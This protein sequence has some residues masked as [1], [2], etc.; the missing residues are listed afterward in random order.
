MFLDTQYRMVPSLSRWPNTQFY[1]GKIRDG[2]SVT[3]DSYV[4]G[5]PWPAGS[6]S[7]FIHC[8]GMERESATGSFRIFEQA[9]VVTQLVKRFLGA[10]SVDVGQVG[11]LS[12]YETQRKDLV[13][14]GL[15]KKIKIANVDGF[16]G[17]EKDVMIIST[18]RSNREHKT[19]SFFNSSHRLCVAFTRAKRG[20]FVLGDYATTWNGDEEGHWCSFLDSTPIYTST[21]TLM[22]RTE[23]LLLRVRASR[24]SPKRAEARVV[25]W[26]ST[27]SLR[28][29]KVGVCTEDMKGMLRKVFE[30]SQQLAEY[31]AFN[32]IL[33]YVLSLTKKKYRAAERPADFKK[34]D[35]KCWTHMIFCEC[36]CVA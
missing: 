13:I 35:R 15:H 9:D 22:P 27:C 34:W 1:Q 12:W 18:V 8:E 28:D 25:Q 33:D 6:A 21:F 36:W 2:V 3:A 31:E 29:V 24:K 32:M 11:I 20:M 10:G 14:S 17:G 16:Q 26:H 5:F 7:V 19:S 23:E 30:V 4:G